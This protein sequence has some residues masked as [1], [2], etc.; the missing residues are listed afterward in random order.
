MLREP[1]LLGCLLYVLLFAAAF[2]TIG[3]FGLLA[4]ERV[5]AFPF[6]FVLMSAPVANWV[7]WKLRH[8]PSRIGVPG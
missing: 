6:F 8:R 5:Q 3:N 2:G 4:R 1:F 7:P